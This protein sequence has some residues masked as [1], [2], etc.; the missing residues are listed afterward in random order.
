MANFILFQLGWLACV[1]GGAHGRPWLGIVVSLAILSWHFWRAQSAWL[2]ARLLLVVA[3][4]G[5]MLDQLMLSLK[6]LG[7]P[8]ANWPGQLLPAWMW[9]LWMLFA[10]TLNVNL[11]W[12]R[13]R[14]LLGAMLG[15]A[16]G[17]LAYLGASRLGA[18]QL[19][20]G[21]ISLMA[22]GLVWAV[23]MPGMMWL[24]V[25]LDGYTRLNI[26]REDFSHV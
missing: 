20:Q 11:R 22:I 14:P 17:P 8:A 2:E 21:P 4:S 24:S 19:L 10:T 18:I 5:G 3:L 16:G 15:F 26:L 23:A 1:L 13:K 25:R 6:L 7:Y 9:M 12:L